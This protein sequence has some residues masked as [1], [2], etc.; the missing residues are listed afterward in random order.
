MEEKTHKPT[1]KKLRDAHKRGEVSKSA[2]LT[3]ALVLG[4]ILLAMAIGLPIAWRWFSDL[5]ALIGVA[6]AER[7]STTRLAATVEWMVSGFFSMNMTLLAVALLSAAAGV[8]VQVRGVFSFE[9]IT[10]KF[11]R[12]NPGENLKNIFSTKQLFELAKSLVD[13]A[14]VSVTLLLVLKSYT[15]EIL[16]VM[17]TDLGTATAVAA[18]V[19]T[20]LFFFS[21]VVALLTSVVD[22]GH[23]KY[24]FLRKQ[25]MSTDELRREHKDVEGD[26]HVRAQRRRLQRA[27]LQPPLRQQVER[28]SVVVTNPTHFAVGVRYVPGE[29]DV[30]Q[31]TV[32]GADDVAAQ[33]RELAKE[34][35]IPVVR[36]PELAR[37]LYAGLE[38]DD[39]VPAEFFEALAAILVAV[40]RANATTATSSE[41]PQ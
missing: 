29:T 2:H 24:Q 23:Q 32:R 33:I 21:F 14:L 15:P 30:P 41:P 26:P 6:A 8:L 37:R 38:V 19:L 36:S 13:V 17:R 10:P 34:Q 3:S 35:A 27:M 28:A 39:E 1:N 18:A 11:E 22:F 12:L 25:R 4:F 40:R 5:F 31:I 7:D 9:P 16:K 20:A